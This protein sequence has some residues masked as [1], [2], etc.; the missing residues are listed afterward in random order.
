MTFPILIPQSLTAF[1]R[2]GFENESYGTDEIDIVTAIVV[3]RYVPVEKILE[4]GY[5]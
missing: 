5:L 4:G 3:S 2:K 1:S